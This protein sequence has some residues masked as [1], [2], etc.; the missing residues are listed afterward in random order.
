MPAPYQSP[1][2]RYLISSALC[3]RQGAALQYR[4]Q[5]S[6]WNPHSISLKPGNW[7]VGCGFRLGSGKGTLSSKNE[8]AAAKN[9]IY[10][11]PW[12]GHHAAGFGWKR[13]GGGCV[14][15]RG[16][17]GECVWVGVKARD[18][19]PCLV[20]TRIT[21][22]QRANRPC[23]ADMQGFWR[24]VAY[25]L[26][27]LRCRCTPQPGWSWL[28]DAAQPETKSTRCRRPGTG[29]VTIY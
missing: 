8:S 26:Q 15:G 3:N 1:S 13:N 27:P 21:M 22:H 16:W 14:V 10:S 4:K 19:S 12:K 20:L 5:P 9:A 25:R 23:A 29:L 7:G 17:C 18:R 28:R 24:P 2:H 11:T 6:A